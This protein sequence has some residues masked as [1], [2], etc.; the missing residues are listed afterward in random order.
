MWVPAVP[1][2]EP[3]AAVSGCLPQSPVVVSVGGVQAVIEKLPSPSGEL[4]VFFVVRVA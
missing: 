4:S 3:F 2:S 1:L